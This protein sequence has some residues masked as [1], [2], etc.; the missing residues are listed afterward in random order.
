MIINARQALEYLPEQDLPMR[1]FAAIALG[2]AY[3]VKG[4]MK[5]A[6]NAR[7]EAIEV[8]RSNT[9]PYFVIAT[10]L[11]MIMTLKAL[12]QLHRAVDVCQQQYKLAETNGLN[13]LVKGL[14]NNLPAEVS[15]TGGLAGDGSRFQET[16]V[17][18]DNEPEKDPGKRH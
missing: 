17:C 11:K 15:V 12:G 6:Y 18:L 13:A 5:A 2:D 14:T 9:S 1:S 4:E 3:T 8:S 7:L 16:L 10:S